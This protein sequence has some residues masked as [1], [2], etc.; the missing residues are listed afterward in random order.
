MRPGD[1]GRGRAGKN[2][3]KATL[4]SVPQGHA[5]KTVY[6]EIQEVCITRA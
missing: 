5:R 4:G 3:D 6:R 2:S 1:D